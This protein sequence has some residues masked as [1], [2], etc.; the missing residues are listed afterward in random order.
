MILNSAEVG[1]QVKNLFKPPVNM[2][3]NNRDIKTSQ[4]SNTMMTTVE[5]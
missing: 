1:V 4:G 2:F 5:L 3:S